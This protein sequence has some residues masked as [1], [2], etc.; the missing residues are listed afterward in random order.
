MTSICHLEGQ[1]M[2]VLRFGRS[3]RSDTGMP[4]AVKRS[5]VERSHNAG[6]H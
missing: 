6:M 3:T 1:V 5:V 4:K 2:E